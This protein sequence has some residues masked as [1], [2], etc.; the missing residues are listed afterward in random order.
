MKP[1]V[2]GDPAWLA[3][4]PHRVAP[5]PGESLVSL[6]LRCD[7]ENHWE[8]GTT[9]TL[10]LRTLFANEVHARMHLADLLV[11]S[12]P[13]VVLLA[14]WLGLP[15]ETIAAAT[16]LRELRRFFGSATS[17]AGDLCYWSV[18][19][20]CPICIHEQ[21]VLLRGHFLFGMSSCLHHQVA[22]VACCACGALLTPFHATTEP[23][24]CSV[25]RKDW[26]MLLPV[27]AAPADLEKEHQILACYEWW[28]RY[29]D[30]ASMKE[31]L[32]WLRDLEG[33]SKHAHR[34]SRLS[35]LSIRIARWGVL[36]GSSY[37]GA[38]NALVSSLDEWDMLSRFSEKKNEEDVFK[39]KEN[40]AEDP[41]SL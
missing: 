17:V 13:L 40:R 28:L 2:L 29:G 38:L 41:S 33:A 7:Q 18:F 15:I 16:Y 21:R 24:T 9:R 23:F 5:K 32:L 1:I 30:V 25:C 8:S 6:L 14:R 31:T 34:A 20:L 4:F 22:L 36:T 39:W 12:Q 35:C 19:H 10:L 37:V 11:P 27:P 3:T 26:G